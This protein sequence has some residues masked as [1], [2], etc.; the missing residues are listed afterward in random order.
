MGTR[1]LFL[2]QLD[3]FKYVAIST[4]LLLLT[5]WVTYIWNGRG[6]DS[7]LRCLSSA[8][9][10]DQRFVSEPDR[11]CATRSDGYGLRNRWMLFSTRGRD[12]TK[13]WKCG[14]E[15]LSDNHSVWIRWFLCSTLC[16][17][18]KTKNFDW[19]EIHQYQEQ[20]FMFL[21]LTNWQK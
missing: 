13:Y 14:A 7:L 8:V 21:F 16:H 2:W 3:Y 9:P 11:N 15:K 19:K 20:L 6:I 5:Q 10:M 17:D 4:L 12:K 1:S 18:N